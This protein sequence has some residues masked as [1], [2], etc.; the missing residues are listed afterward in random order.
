MI[1]SSAID[2]AAFAVTNFGNN[3]YR[4]SAELFLRGIKENGVV[5]VDSNGQLEDELINNVNAI[6]LKYGQQIRIYLEE[7]LKNKKKKLVKCKAEDSQILSQNNHKLQV[8]QIASKCG[9]DAVL[10]NDPIP[11]TKYACEVISITEYFNSSYESKRYIFSNNVPPLDQLSENIAED[12][13]SRIAKYSKWIRFYDK[14]IGTG[15]NTS[16]FR[17][18]LKYIL[19]LYKKYGYY[20]N[21][22]EW[23]EIIT[24]EKENIDEEDTQMESARK[25][26]LNIRAYKK[27]KLELLDPLS[28][29]FGFQFKLKVKKDNNRIFHARHIEAQ[30]IIVLFDR[31]FDLFTPN[32]Q[33]KRNILKLDNSSFDHLRECRGLPESECITAA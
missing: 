6:P 9:I 1:M 3:G 7:I 2:P 10:T 13:I 30:S 33:F 29:E 23:I 18:G 19:N 4:N 28:K 27:V 25:L 26:D 20:S 12:V 32:G 16:H 21:E 15:S 5:I 17:N 8:Y 14:Q 22:V 11:N 31:G 24:V